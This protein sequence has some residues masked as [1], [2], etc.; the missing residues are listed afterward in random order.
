MSPGQ[1]PFALLQLL[2]KESRWREWSTVT[3]ERAATSEPETQARVGQHDREHGHPA[4][5]VVPTRSPARPR[6]AGVPHSRTWGRDPTPE[7]SLEGRGWLRPRDDEETP[8]G[9]GPTS[10]TLRKGL[11]AE[12]SRPPKQARP[13][14]QAWVRKDRNGS[15]YSTEITAS[16]EPV[17]PEVPALLEHHCV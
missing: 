2:A 3:R 11:T 15:M 16:W 6:A 13:R 17:A 12:A 10:Q 8:P 1:Q 4:E 5:H 9:V 14:A 7:R